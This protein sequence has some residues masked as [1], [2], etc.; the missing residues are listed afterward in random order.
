MADGKIKLVLSIPTPNFTSPAGNL[1]PLNSTTFRLAMFPPLEVPEGYEVSLLKATIPYTQPNVGAAADNITGFPNGDN[2]ISI[3]FAG[4]GRADFIFSLG[5]YGVS[6]IQSALNTFAQ[7]AG[8]IASGVSTPMFT[9]TPI[10]ATQQ[11]ALTV[12][13]VPLAGGVFPAGGIVIDFLNPSVAALNNSIGPLLGW[14]TSGGGATL[15]IAAG[16]S[17]PVTFLAPNTANMAI[18]SD[19][20]LFMS[21]LADGYSNGATS[22]ILDVISL[23]A[24]TPN[25]LIQFEAKIPFPSKVRKGAYS[26]IDFFFTAQ[27]GT[28]LALAN[29]GAPISLSIL[30]TPIHST[31]KILDDTGRPV[32]GLSLRR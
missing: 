19:Y 11:L 4:G 29:F 23:G 22:S 12:S 6:D 26:A 9:V 13:P 28:K 15:T 10:Q 32:G 17:A 7:N 2:R 18:Y 30:F 31:V 14:P 27:D 24:A 1:I 16:G 3:N 21:I 25:Q 20:F 5:L 8:W